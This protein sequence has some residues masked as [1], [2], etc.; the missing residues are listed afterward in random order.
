MPDNPRRGPLAGVRV[1][2]IENYLAGNHATFLMSMLGAEVIKVEE[3][4]VGDQLRSIGP[5]VPAPWGNGDQRS[6]GEVRVMGNKRSVAINLRHPG[7]LRAFFR[8]V[9]SV[10]VVYSNMKPTS[11]TKLG[12]TFEALCERNGRIVFTTLSGFGHPDVVTSGPWGDWPAFDIIAQGLAGLQFRAEGEEGRPGYNGLPL[13]DE[14]TSILTVVGTTSALFDRERTGEPQRVD[15]A[16]HD[17]MVYLNEL[18]V[19]AMSFSGRLAARGR[20]G[21]SAPYGSYPTADGWVNIAVGG[22]FVWRRFC[23]AIGRAELGDDERFSTSFLRVSHL[24][25]LD[26]LVIAWTG[27]RTTIEIVEILQAKGV[28]SAPVLEIRQVLESPQV[29]ARNMLL[30]VDDPIVGQK[31]IAGNPI[32]MRGLEDAP[33]APAPFVGADTAALLAEL[34]GLDAT[35]IATLADDGAIGIHA[36]VPV[37]GESR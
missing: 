34:G 12:I 7:G 8:L 10:D 19:G 14:V 13:G 32:K 29:A 28:P 3:P 27:A 31:Q 37:G 6:P 9:A 5:H 22:N 30:T 11:L 20:S 33:P 24:A 1:L 4:G 17:A 25:E 23:E 36:A 21:T 26:E 16:M 18:A 15:V 35:E 2:S